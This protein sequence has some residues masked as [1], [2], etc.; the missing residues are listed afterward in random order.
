KDLAPDF[1]LNYW[2]LALLNEAMANV[3]AARENFTRYQELISEQSA[4]DEAALHLKTL[5]AKKS[6]YDEEVS[7]A[8]D[9]LSDLFNRGMN[10]TF[11]MDANRRAIRARRAQ[12]KKK[13]DRAKDKNRVGGFTVP[14]AYAQQQLSEASEHLQVALA[15]FPLGAEANE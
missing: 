2:K 9:I 15:L 5:D 7:E 14:Y 10:L 3:D 13:Q 1:A 8:E 6:K 11:N 4:K 12:I